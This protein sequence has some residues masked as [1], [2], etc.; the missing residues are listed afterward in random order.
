[1]LLTGYNK[2]RDTVIESI[3]KMLSKMDLYD[4]RVQESGGMGSYETFYIDF[5]KTEDSE[6]YYIRFSGHNAGSGNGC[7]FSLWNDDFNTLTELKKAVIK[8]I[9]EVEQK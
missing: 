7:N 9:E 6:Q 1:M 4:Y 3:E 2:K 5:Q 8:I